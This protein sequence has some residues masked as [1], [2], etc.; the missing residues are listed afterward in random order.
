MN[1]KY[2]FYYE[3]QVLSLHKGIKKWFKRFLPFS[4]LT[5]FEP[6]L[7][8]EEPFSVKATCLFS[9]LAVSLTEKSIMT[10]TA[11]V[12]VSQQSAHVNQHDADKDLYFD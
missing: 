4:P 10:M 2:I 6:G 8:A 12:S 5:R 9:P 1:F 7:L 11:A 3:N